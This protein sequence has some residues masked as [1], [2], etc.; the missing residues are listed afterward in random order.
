MAYLKEEK[1]WKITDI[2]INRQM[3]VARVTLKGYESKEASD[4]HEMQK[5]N[6]NVVLQ[7]GY[8]PFINGTE[9]QIA[10]AYKKV[11]EKDNYFADAEVV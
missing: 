3:N 2:E 1:Y 7:G 10:L 5:E 4:K 9:D 6:K 11:A 8:F